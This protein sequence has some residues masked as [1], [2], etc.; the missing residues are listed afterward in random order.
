MHHLCSEISEFYKY[1]KTKYKNHFLDYLL[2]LYESD[3]R[4]FKLNVMLVSFF[5]KDS[6]FFCEELFFYYYKG[7]IIEKAKEIKIPEKFCG[8]KEYKLIFK[9]MGRIQLHEEECIV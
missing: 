8:M 9:I 5:N 7:H 2:Y 1:Y 6:L 3:K 4:Y